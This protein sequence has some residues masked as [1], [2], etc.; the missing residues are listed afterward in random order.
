MGLLSLSP[1]FI[2]SCPALS[3]PGQVENKLDSLK[4]RGSLTPFLLLKRQLPHPSPLPLMPGSSLRS[5]SSQQPQVRQR[6]NRMGWNSAPH[7]RGG[8]F[9]NLLPL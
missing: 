9:F 3:K 6:E 7:I 8:V 1:A 5:P 4:L 2:R